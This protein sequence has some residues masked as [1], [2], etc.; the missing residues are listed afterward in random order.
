MDFFPAPENKMPKKN[1]MS[2]VKTRPIKTEPLVKSITFSFD[3]V[4]GFR[5]EQLTIDI[6]PNEDKID[7]KVW[8]S[9]FQW[10]WGNQRYREIPESDDIDM[11]V[12]GLP[13]ET[14][15]YSVLD[16]KGEV[17]EKYSIPLVEYAKQQLAVQKQ[18]KE[19]AEAVD[20]ESDE[21]EFLNAIESICN[22]FVRNTFV[23]FR[24]C[25][26]NLVRRLAREKEIEGKECPVLQTSLTYDNANQIK[27]CKHWL[28]KEAL[29]GMVKAADGSNYLN[30]PLCRER[31]HS[32]MGVH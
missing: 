11:V 9:N 31:F 7:S 6:I 21:P 30:C 24:H 29:E 5:N 19:L 8:N 27:E 13:I 16:E 10:T 17:M 20:W 22:I 15:S 32:F 4:I 1:K 3:S 12:M 26:D 14:L 23:R 18:E 25:F 28:S 2:I